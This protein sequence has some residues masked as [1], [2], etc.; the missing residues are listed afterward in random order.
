MQISQRNPERWYRIKI[1]HAR[2]ST[3]RQD[4]TQ[5]AL[6]WYRQAADTDGYA[7][8]VGYRARKVVGG[9]VVHAHKPSNVRMLLLPGFKSL[10]H[11]VTSVD[12]LVA[13]DA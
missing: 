9:Y 8:G 10:N 2:Q 1:V 5:L 12:A 7:S 11:D 4:A 6:Q 3:R 13:T